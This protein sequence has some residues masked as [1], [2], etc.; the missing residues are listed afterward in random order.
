M[1]KLVFK[2]NNCKKWHIIFA[3]LIVCLLILLSIR[4]LDEYR[5]SDWGFGD[6]QI[7]LTL[8]QWEKEGWFANRFLIIPQGHFKS[9]RLLDEPE[10]RH[11]AH[12]IC[13]GSSWRV[14][15]RL[16]YT[17]YPSLY[18]MIY[19]LLFKIV[20]GNIFFIRMLSVFFSI[21]A[22]ILMYILFSKITSPPISFITVLFY[23]LSSSFFGYADAIADQPITDLL[24][25][26]FMLLI[27]FSTRTQSLRQRKALMI[28]AW[29]I[30]FIA[31][32][33]SLDSVFF[34]YLWLIGWDLLERRGFRWKTYI[35]FAMAPL[36]A[37]FFQFLQNVWYLGLNNAIMDIKDTYIARSWLIGGANRLFIF[38]RALMKLLYISYKPSGLLV[39]LFIFYILYAKFLSDNKNDTELPS[40]RLLT[41]LFLCGLSFVFFVPSIVTMSY[42]ARQ[43]TPSIALLTSGVTWSFFKKYNYVFNYAKKE[44]SLFMH[45]AAITYILLSGIVISVFWYYFILSDRK[46]LYN[47]IRIKNHPDVLL[48]KKI[49]SIP[50]KYEA[51]IFDIGSFQLF[52][53]PTYVL[54]YPQIHPITEYYIGSKPILCFTQPEALVT[55]LL[56]MVKRSQY[57]FSPVL[58]AGN[59]TYID[60]ILNILKEKEVLKQE[61]EQPYVIL[62]KYVLILTDCLKLQ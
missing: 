17:H 26:S 20:S 33:S 13:P 21:G 42:E 40:L 44:N 58:V 12:G 14:G 29:I 54:G 50:T 61:P 36:I 39:L 34:V 24:R 46:S 32:L 19:A 35:I 6:A 31:S 5:W 25:F 28:S 53:D 1:N 43:I 30:E 49:K 62:N 23:S 52:W 38:Y 56:Y 37:H 27:V 51:V 3:T 16:W 57:K 2:L 11:H 8:N 41:L 18:L 22:L 10:L 59:V 15:P 45:K 48:A 4:A 7:M 47:N 60:K 55:D 9:I